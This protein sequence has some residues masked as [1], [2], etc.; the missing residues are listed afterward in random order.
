MS[1][2]SNQSSMAL[3]TV[4]VEAWW[5][6]PNCSDCD[7]LSSS[8]I[9]RSEGL[10]SPRCSVAAEAAVDAKYYFATTATPT[11]YSPPRPKLYCRRCL[12]GHVMYRMV[13]Q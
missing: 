2:V 4:E 3:V 11:Y 7:K 6:R 12:H 10:V 9:G 8:P 13:N 1:S 5:R